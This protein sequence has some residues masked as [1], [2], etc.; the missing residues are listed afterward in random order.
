MRLLNRCSYV[1]AMIFLMVV[2]LL[3]GSK[4]FY[5]IALMFLTGL[6]MVFLSSDEFNI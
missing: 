2:I 4:C 1:V 6:D 5:G 3:G